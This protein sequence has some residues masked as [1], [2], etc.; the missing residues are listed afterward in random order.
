[1]QPVPPDKQQALVE[2]LNGLCGGH[3]SPDERRK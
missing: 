1:M 2:R 3:N